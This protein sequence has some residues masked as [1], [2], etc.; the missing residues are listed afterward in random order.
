MRLQPYMGSHRFL[1]PHQGRVKK[2]VELSLRI[3]LLFQYIQ[4]ITVL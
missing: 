1:W 3:G 2:W 4:S